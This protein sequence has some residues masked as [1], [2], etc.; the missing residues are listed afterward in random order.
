M[1]F[2]DVPANDRP[3]SFITPRDVAA[4]P[5]QESPALEYVGTTLLIILVE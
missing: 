4:M 5:R 1:I 2:V 3:G